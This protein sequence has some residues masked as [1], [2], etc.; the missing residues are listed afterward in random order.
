MD[1][2]SFINRLPINNVAGSIIQ[3]VWDE[4]FIEI[5]ILSGSTAYVGTVSLASL[6]N[7]ADNLE[8]HSETFIEE[9]KVALTMGSEDFTYLLEKEVFSWRKKNEKGFNLIYGSVTL[10]EQ[11]NFEDKIIDK[12]IEQ[13]Y[14]LKETLKNTTLELQASRNHYKN[15]NDHY[16]DLMNTKNNVEQSLI[17]KFILLLN[18][19]KEQI[20]KLQNELKSKDVNVLHLANAAD[21]DHDMEEEANID[22]LSPVIV[23]R[24]KSQIV[25]DSSSES[26]QSQ[27]IIQKNLPKRLIPNVKRKLPAP[28][29][30]L[31]LEKDQITDIDESSDISKRISSDEK[32][33]AIA[34][35]QFD[36]AGSG[37]DK[38]A[39]ESDT[40]ALLN[41]MS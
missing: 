28:S 27:E 29:T 30:S 19:K 13:N 31:E 9:T 35:K 41:D 7:T 3:T 40:V 23:P 2:E 5:S 6:K 36:S 34:T 25:I 38:S 37:S 4:N 22:M 21:G 8:I 39:Y 18:A 1:K 26:S 15:L 24:K 33:I 16:E 20:L 17:N 12:L 32:N 11:T 14:N 10:N